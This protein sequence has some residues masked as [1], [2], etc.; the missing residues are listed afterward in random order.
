MML[1]ISDISN[2]FRNAM[3]QSGIVTDAEI[4]PDGTLHRFHINGDKRSSLNGWYVLYLNNVAG[5]AFGNWKSGISHKWCVKSRNSMA[6]EEWA[7]HCHRIKNIRFQREQ[8]KMIE[9]EQAAKRA[10][11]IWNTAKPAAPFHPYLTKKHIKPHNLRQKNIQL[12]VPLIDVKGNLRNLQKIDANGNKLFLRGGQVRG[13][14]AMLGELPT[15]GCLYICEGFATASTIHKLTN[16]TVIAAMNAGNLKPV[17]LAL[18]NALAIEVT[19]IIAAD[20][21]YL[22]NPNIGINKGRDAAESIGARLTWPHFP[23]KNCAC[24]DF[25]DLYNCNKLQGGLK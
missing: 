21:D 23:C 2:S 14:F 9:Q 5:G 10:H 20:N 12:L 16:K 6:Q 19:I 4:I 1:S 8:A 25:N 18:R 22:S 24:T 17:A 3:I 15:S 7:E 13:V 11:K